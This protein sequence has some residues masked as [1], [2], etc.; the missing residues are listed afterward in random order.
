MK[1]KPVFSIKTSTDGVL[2]SRT[3][4]FQHEDSKTVVPTWASFRAKLPSSKKVK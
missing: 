1:T 4:K 3:G 2:V